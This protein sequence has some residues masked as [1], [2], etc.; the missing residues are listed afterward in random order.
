MT[1]AA[2]VF[3]AI[4]LGLGL[5]RDA[6]AQPP[7]PPPPPPPVNLSADSEPPAPR[8]TGLI[9]GRVLD[10]RTGRPIPDATIT[11]T[12][13]GRMPNVLTDGE[14]R[15][16][17]R[18][19]P[20][21]A[22]TI[23][24]AKPG[25]VTG[26]FGRRRP[27]GPSQ[28]LR[29]VD[30]GKTGD[31][32]IAMWRF[33][34]I[35]GTVVDEAGE[36]I[37]NADVRA[38]RRTYLAGRRGYAPGRTTRTDDR[39]QY[40]LWDLTPG[41]YI[42]AVESS[43][44]SVDAATVDLYRTS[45]G[46]GTPAGS[47]LLREMIASGSSAM[48]ILGGGQR[49]GDLVHS[50]GRGPTAPPASDPSRVLVYPTTFFPSAPSSAEATT[51]SVGSGE[52]RPATDIQV[53]LQAGVRISGHVSGPEGPAALMT[54]RLVPAASADLG[55]DVE[56]A[57]A[58]SD[59]NGAFTFLGVPP[60]AYVLR[61]LKRPT[62]VPS[63]NTTTTTM[64]QSGGT[65]TVG[66]TSGIPGGAPPP[67]PAGPTL[68]ATL[69]VS[70]GERDQLDLA[71]ELRSGARIR[72][73]LE[74]DG[75]AAKP[76]PQAL[77]RAA[78]LVE[79]ANGRAGDQLTPGRVDERGS[80]ETIGL[81]AGKYFIR[82]RVS[83]PGWTF[84]SATHNGR[85][86]ADLPFDLGAGDLR[87]VVITFT[88]RPA[89]LSGAVS[90]ARGPDGDASV[91]IFPADP[92]HWSDWGLNPRRVRTVRCDV[93]GQYTASGIPPGDY[94][95]AALPDAMAAEW[96]NPQSMDTLARQATSVTIVAGEKKTL[97]L[98]T[99]EPAR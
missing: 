84:Q 5:A 85:D 33:G 28:Q 45:V 98:R 16:V 48:S 92:E 53:R 64:I 96:E 12:G 4:V 69:P 58:M 68:W 26:A 24:A 41:D 2:A 88:D 81:P 52:E 70:V 23:T 99:M 73:R 74:F 75:T 71:V 78:I 89:E 13:R 51:V 37:V 31:V 39:G 34:V 11:L 87:D 19:V 7:P 57:A 55:L 3:G 17:Y 25:Y 9:M 62:N 63:P 54:L 42:V 66:V 67:L 61:A 90:G 94:Y 30:G 29:L 18:A 79:P 86:L 80:F 27:E 46:S 93:S 44:V 59:R 40:R 8:G 83:I 60:G 38:Y 36:P 14:G 10:A 95:V 77:Q 20:P 76:A 56:T 82:T 49:I 22:F 43:S 65:V 6:G 15:F 35:T 97:N 47:A 21:G 50:S 72:G 32:T 1:R 91:V